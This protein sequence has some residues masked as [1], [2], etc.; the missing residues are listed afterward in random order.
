[1]LMKTSFAA[2]LATLYF[3]GAVQVFRTDQNLVHAACWRLS[4]N[5]TTASSVSVAIIWPIYALGIGSGT[6]MGMN[7]IESPFACAQKKAQL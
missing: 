3:L 4:I 5:N 1:M 2:V 7:V 6:V